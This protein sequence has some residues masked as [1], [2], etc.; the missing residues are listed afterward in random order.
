M[1]HALEL[2]IQSQNAPAIESAAHTLKGAVSHFRAQAVYDAAFVLEQ[3]GRHAQIDDVGQSFEHL[4]NLL[5]DLTKELDAF[6]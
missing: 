5:R 4:V 6:L 1:T 2:A 3:Q